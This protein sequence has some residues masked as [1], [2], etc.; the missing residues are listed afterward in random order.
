MKSLSYH[1]CA[2]LF[3]TVVLI[4]HR[5][6]ACPYVFLCCMYNYWVLSYFS[7]ISRPFMTML[8]LITFHATRNARYLCQQSLG[9]FAQVIK[10]HA[11]TEQIKLSHQL[12]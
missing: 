2:E 11:K 1:V 6:S 5:I 12:V 7:K 8:A 10:L 4:V 3:I 9:M